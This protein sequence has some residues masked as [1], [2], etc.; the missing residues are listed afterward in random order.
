MKT[1]ENNKHLPPS[2]KNDKFSGL[3]NLEAF[4]IVIW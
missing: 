4:H 2:E 3:Q 1:S